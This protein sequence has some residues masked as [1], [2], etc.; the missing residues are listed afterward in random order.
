MV[1]EVETNFKALHRTLDHKMAEPCSMRVL[2][3]L[4]HVACASPSEGLVLPTHLS[5]LNVPQ[6]N[7]GNR[8]YCGLYLKCPSEAHVLNTWSLSGGA[9]LRVCR[10]FKWWAKLTEVGH[11]VTID[12][13]M[14]S[15]SIPPGPAFLG[16]LPG[17]LGNETF[18]STIPSHS[19]LNP[20]SL[21]AKLLS[22][23]IGYFVIRMQR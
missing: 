6:N 13:P 21:W 12:R 3:G 14:K 7:L 19:E 4:S 22:S 2:C 11:W 23:S 20:L 1:V 9:G 15:V 8:C 16:P 5:C 10:T 17:L 18:Y